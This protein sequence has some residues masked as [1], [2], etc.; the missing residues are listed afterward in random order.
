MLHNKK[1]VHVSKEGE[2]RKVFL[3]SI[4]M[5]TYSG[6]LHVCL[7][8]RKGQKQRSNSIPTGIED[9]TVDSTHG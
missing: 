5:E 3:A 9:Y 1:T 8:E 6:I 4:S 7:P 2:V